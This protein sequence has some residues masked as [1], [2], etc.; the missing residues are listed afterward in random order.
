MK[1]GITWEPPQVL[2]DREQAAEVRSMYAALQNLSDGRRSQGKR[3]PLALIQVFLLLAKA[4]GETTLLAV[5]EWIRRRG[6]WLQEVQPGIRPT[7]PCAATCSNVLRAIDPDERKTV[8]MSLLT[9][10]RAEEREAEEQRHLA[11]DGK[12]LCGTLHHEADDQQKM[13]HVSLYETKTGIIVKELVVGEKESEQTRAK[14]FVQPAFIKGRMVTADALHTRTEVC[15]ASTAAGGDYLLFAKGNQPTLQEDVFLCFQ[16]P[17]VDCHDGQ[18]AHTTNLGH[19][20]L[21]QRSISASN[22]V[23]DFLSKTWPGVGQVFR[24]QRRFHHPFNW[25]I[26]NVYGIT[27]FSPEE[28]SPERLLELIRNHWAIE[29]KLHSRRDVTLGE[30]ACQV[31]K[32][33]AP[34]TLAVLNRFLLAVFDWLDVRNVASHMRFFAAQPFQALC[35]FMLSLESMK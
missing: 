18:T 3:S 27:S 22:E 12:T 30:D 6:E 26:P 31:R 19:G 5:A 33:Q 8:R 34:R 14:A 24:L 7:F 13:H 21:E 16:E 17:P 32:G 23:N 2:V 15:V 9:R 4:A 1:N 29:K 10:V 35:L 28:A 25:S 11:C 20:R